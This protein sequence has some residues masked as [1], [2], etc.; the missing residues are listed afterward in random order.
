MRTPIPPNP[1]QDVRLDV[2]ACARCRFGTERQNSCPGEGDAS[3]TVMVIGEAPSRR[4][5]K[6]G[7]SLYGDSRDL[8]D[9][10]LRRA[11]LRPE[12]VFVTNLLKCA[13]LVDAERSD[14]T[15][16][17]K[18]SFPDDDSEPVDRCEKWLKAQLRIV[19]PRAVVLLGH[20]ALQHVLLKGAVGQAKPYGP[21]IERL[22]RRRDTYGE[23]RFACAYHPRRIAASKNHYDEADSVASIERVAEYVK[24]VESGGMP[25]LEDLHE[26]KSVTPPQYQQR[27]RLFGRSKPGQPTQDGPTK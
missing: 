8:L 18:M 20:R 19:Q 22:S 7:V 24:A 21:W 10:W 5:D 15:T 26:V 12:N 6:A 4:E 9:Q 11:G 13:P 3:A 1:L 16:Y 23:I 25:P 27:I 17:R 2:M 14:G